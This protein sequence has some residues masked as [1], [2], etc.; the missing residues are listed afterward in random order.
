MK[1]VGEISIILFS[2]SIF[3]DIRKL[4]EVGISLLFA[5]FQEKK[6]SYNVDTNSYSDNDCLVFTIP[7]MVSH[8][9][10]YS[11]SAYPWNKF[12]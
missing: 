3:S 11:Y 12:P 8:K 10:K 4:V 2:K 1:S 5:S 7:L 9:S 6:S